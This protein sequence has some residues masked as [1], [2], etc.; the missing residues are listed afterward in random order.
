MV[1]G[2]TDSRL[3]T[4]WDLDRVVEENRRYRG[5][6]L[7]VGDYCINAHCYCFNYESGE[8]SS[9]TVEYFSEAAPKVIANSVDEFFALLLND[10]DRAEV[11]PGAD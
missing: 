2:E 4:L 9:V 5:T 3:F 8:R 11:L 10:P 6:G 1:D 7:L